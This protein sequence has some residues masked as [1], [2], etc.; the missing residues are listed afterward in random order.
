MCTLALG[1]ADKEVLNALRVDSEVLERITEDFAVML[2]GDAFK[3]HSF[4]ETKDISGV[5][6]LSGKVWSLPLDQ[7]SHSPNFSQIV[8]RFSAMIG[9]ASE[10]VET[11]DAD[12]IKMCKFSGM[13]DNNF[14]KVLR[15][16][17]RFVTAIASKLRSGA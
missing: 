16:V 12:H 14:C 7:K 3:V 17:E 1:R 15:A 5:P 10:V 6:W 8:D 13:D 4:L 2:K 9:D 11:I